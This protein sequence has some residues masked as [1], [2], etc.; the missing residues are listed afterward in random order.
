MRLPPPDAISHDAYKTRP[1]EWVEIFLGVKLWSKQKDI[2]R[3][4]VDYPR[5][6][7]VSGHG[8]GK[9]F[10]AGVALLWYFFT[11]T[12]SICLVTG[13][14]NRQVKMAVMMNALK[15]AHSSPFPELLPMR[16]YK[17]EIRMEIDGVAQH[18]W[19]I[20]GFAAD[21]PDAVQ[22]IHAENLFLVVDE[23]SGVDE[24][25]Y[26][27]AMSLGQTD[28][29]RVLL[30]GNPMYKT[31]FFAESHRGRGDYHCMKISVLDSPNFTGEPVPH[32]AKRG[33]VKPI[34]V[35]RLEADQ[36]RNSYDYQVRVLADF[37]LEDEFSLI[38][39]EMLEEAMGREPQPDHELERVLGV[40]IAGTGK[41]LAVWI[42]IFG[43]RLEVMAT[44]QVTKSQFDAARRTMD[45]CEEHGFQ[46]VCIDGSA[47]GGAALYEKFVELQDKG[48]GGGVS[49]TPVD[50]GG[51]QDQG[52]PDSFFNRRAEMAWNLMEWIRD[53]A[54]IPNDASTR[55]LV[56]ELTELRTIRTDGDGAG[57]VRLEKKD[58]M[59]KRL[60][61][62]SPD[63]AD[64]AM[65]ACHALRHG[66]NMDAALDTLRSML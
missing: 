29:A 53:E 33:L 54:I 63:Y 32:A 12:D 48:R 30:I 41:D 9:S 45:L 27:A 4:L 24:G 35:D 25:I 28:N 40:D 11:H 39:I 14:N 13:P 3:A 42:G 62:A 20:Y 16:L 17:E 34:W 60:G 10:T 49:I 52:V 26:D 57:D 8:V 31:G 15:L 18:D 56:R 50:F 36:G 2:L 55:R 6:S 46:K 44:E 1:V 58:E 23:A 37:P 66:V 7:V 5:V 19:L 51:R 21:N 43:N 38:T 61:G 64:A 59:R 47:M 65:L 22:G